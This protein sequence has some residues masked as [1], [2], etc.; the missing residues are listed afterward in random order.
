MTPPKK[1]GDL[2]HFWEL[3][4]QVA[5]NKPPRAQNKES[6]EAAHG[7]KRKQRKTSP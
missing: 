5:G 6:K 4:R 2:P 1:H 7:W 3:A